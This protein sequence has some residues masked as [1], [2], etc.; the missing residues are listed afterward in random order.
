[1]GTPDEEQ[2]WDMHHHE[3]MVVGRDKQS[4]KFLVL[5]FISS[6]LADHSV[7]PVPTFMG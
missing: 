2:T 1:M 6:P 7:P 5:V 4:V 3:S